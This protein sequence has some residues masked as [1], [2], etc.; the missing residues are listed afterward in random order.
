M[1][2]PLSKSAKLDW[3]QK[4]WFCDA[5]KTGTNV[6]SASLSNG[7]TVQFILRLYF[8]NW[9]HKKRKSDIFVHYAYI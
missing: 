7:F 2:I 9:E 3:K 5:V 4:Q 8:E 1:A 6:I